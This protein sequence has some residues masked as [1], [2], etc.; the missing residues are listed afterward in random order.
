MA[1]QIARSPITWFAALML[2]MG[3]TASALAFLQLDSARLAILTPPTEDRGPPS[4]LV[5]AHDEI[6][7]LQEFSTYSSCREA[8]VEIDVGTERKVHTSCVKK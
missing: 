4:I 5:L 6:V 8:K 1:F 3:A 2:V 7:R